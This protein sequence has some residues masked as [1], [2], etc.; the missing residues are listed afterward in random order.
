VAFPTPV[1][2][3]VVRYSYLW[4]S[5]HARGQ[6]E[7]VKDRPCAIVLTTA[8]D[9]GDRAA[10]HPFPPADPRL[11]IEL[12]HATK[13]RP[14]LDD[15]RSWVV[16]TEANRFAWPGPD[17]VPSTLGDASSV[18]YGLLP[19]ALFEKIRLTFIEALKARIAHAVPRTE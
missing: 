3:L 14:G 2:G 11:G 8:G 5:E 18:A 9:G 1:P 13:R 12:P 17:L 7:D 6:E 16:M 15:A 19:Y 10:V 4:A